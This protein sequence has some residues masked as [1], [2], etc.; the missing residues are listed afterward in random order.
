MVLPH[1]TVDRLYVRTVC[2][3]ATQQRHKG[4]KMNIIQSEM[5]LRK[6]FMC[7]STFCEWMMDVG[8]KI[9]FFVP[10]YLWVL[11]STLH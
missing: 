5:F 2:A 10:L 9:C 8:L 6:N 11:W 7:Y 1:F 3:V 4:K